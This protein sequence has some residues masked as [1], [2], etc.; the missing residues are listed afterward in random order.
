M[1][2]IKFKQNKRNAKITLDSRNKSRAT[3]DAIFGAFMGIGGVSVIGAILLIFF[4]LAYVVLPLFGS[5]KLD[6]STGYNIDER[7]KILA[8]SIDE[9]SEIIF[10]AHD[11]GD[12]VFSSMQDKKEIL[13][14]SLQGKKTLN[15]RITALSLSDPASRMMA[16][17]TKNGSAYLVQT[18]YEIT[19]PND[20]RMISPSL[21][22]P[23]GKA[24]LE[25]DRSKSAILK[26]SGQFSDGNGVIASLTDDNRL[27]I[28]Y[29]T[30][31]SSLFSDEVEIFYKT[32]EVA[33]IT[34]PVRFIE[35]SVNQRNLA[36]LSADGVLSMYD[37][38]SRN[39]IELMDKVS[40][41]QDNE[42]VTD[43]K[44]LSSGISLIIG[45]SVGHITQWSAVRDA[46]NIYSLKQIRGFDSMPAS[47]RSIAPE[48]YRKGFGVLDDDRNLA[49]YNA[50]AN[51]RVAFLDKVGLNPIDIAICPRSK[52]LL[53][54]ENDTGLSLYTIKNDHPE[55]SFNA[56]L[57]KVWYESREEPEYIWQSSAANSDFE[58]KYS[59]MPLVFGTI[60]A[61]LYSLLFAAPLAIF[62]AVYTAYF[63]APKMRRVVKPTIEIMEALPTVILG[64]LA[65]LWF[66]PFVEKNLAGFFLSIIAIPI[67][68]I[69]M[70][71]IWPRTPKVL[72]RAFPE[73]WESLLLIPV[74]CLAIWGA[75]SLGTQ[76]ESR[77]FGG[78]LPH[79]LNLNYDIGYDQR[80]SLVVGIAIGFAVIP[81]IFSIS[82]DAVY[83]V[84]RSLTNGSLA[85]GAT[86]WQTVY[87][88]ILLTASPGIFSACMIGMGRAVGET[89][90]VLMATGNTP[91]MNMNI[92]EGFRAL[93]ANIAV[94]MPESAVNS[95]HYRIL[96]LAAFFLFLV[97]FVVNTI[98]E[99]VRQRLRIKYANL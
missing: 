41:V 15:E 69:S 20:E 44:F 29:V 82:E 23:V 6:F 79:W 90:I 51:R 27:L 55:V 92:F 48:Y 91:I 45:S 63:M 31:E 12:L 43:I 64:F 19:Y 3:K 2:I 58:P 88:V 34:V 10:S 33:K 57:G 75:L 83:G 9:Y 74:I 50:T 87:R 22:Y 67:S 86:P 77:F 65:G 49:V 59:L 24:P 80:N 30:A 68:T 66:A 35:L 47:I 42:A 17:G 5:A 7:G 37:V 8:T 94:E 39:S 78:N 60:K 13:T 36:L 61:T 70:A 38:S 99:I 84:P 54:T 32:I 72:K 85:L 56:L 46:N 53:I 4:Y 52:N 62:G 11:N 1:S 25:V 95:T 21:L 98:S 28:T 18:E 89:M 81:T 71:L 26:I 14:E 96:F 93:S 40:V 16:I 73:G 76:I 97:T